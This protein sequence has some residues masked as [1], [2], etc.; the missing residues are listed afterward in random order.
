M[1]QSTK[2][3]RIIQ[4]KNKL[5][6]ISMGNKIMTQYLSDIKVKVDLIAAS[7]SPISIEDIIFYA[8]NGL[9]LSYQSFKIA[10][11]T[12]LQP[13]NLKDFYSLLCS[14]EMIQTNETTCQ[15]SGIQTTLI[16]HHNSGRGQSSSNTNSH[17]RYN[18]NH[19]RGRNI[20]I[21]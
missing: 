12:N 16:T 2:K 10:T 9:P 1:L 3:A 7:R 21:E 18:P 4:F 17:G 6:N 14:E 20:N 13:L 5:H 8:L 19:D 11:H 15:G